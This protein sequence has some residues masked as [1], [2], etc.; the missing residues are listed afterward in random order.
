VGEVGEVKEAEEEVEKE[1]EGW[2]P[3]VRK[4]FKRMSTGGK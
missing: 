4:N 2:L 3:K 1:D